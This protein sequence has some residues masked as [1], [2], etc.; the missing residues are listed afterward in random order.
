M[1][2]EVSRIDI[3][4]YLCVIPI[5]RWH[6]YRNQASEDCTVIGKVGQSGGIVCDTVDV[7]QIR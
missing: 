3:L 4:K 6:L 2:L 7:L 1:R 5:S